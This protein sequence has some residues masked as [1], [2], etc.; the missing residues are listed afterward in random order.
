MAPCLVKAGCPGER[1][2]YQCGVA[3]QGHR[4][5]VVGDSAQHPEL[6]V[7]DG[8]TPAAAIGRRA[9]DLGHPVELAPPV[10]GQGA[11]VLERARAATFGVEADLGRATIGVH[12]ALETS[13]AHRSAATTACSC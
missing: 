1:H 7:I 12:D 6:V 13:G 5:V 8:E 9:H 4:T 11:V 2:G 10:R 3:Q